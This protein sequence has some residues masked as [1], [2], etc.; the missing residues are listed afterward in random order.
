MLLSDWMLVG[1]Y[2]AGL[3]Y[4]R[5]PHTDPCLRP[6]AKRD[7]DTR[8]KARRGASCK[9]SARPP[10]AG[11]QGARLNPREWC[12]KGSP[13]PS[14]VPRQPPWPLKHRFG[15]AKGYE[16]SW[17]QPRNAQLKQ[18]SPSTTSQRYPAPSQAP[19]PGQNRT[20]P[21]MPPSPH[22]PP[23]PPLA[24]KAHA[25]APPGRKRATRA[26]RSRARA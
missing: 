5:Q 21:P 23:P 12:R 14:A 10:A 18:E 4:E 9:A 1:H 11:L 8:T 22:R 6:Q 17:H 20:A 2:L 25:L 24:P 19:Q 3:N 26:C 7:G 15:P 13:D 16:N